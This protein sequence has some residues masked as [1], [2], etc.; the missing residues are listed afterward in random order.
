MVSDEKIGYLKINPLFPHR[1]KFSEIDIFDDKIR[2]AA[3]LHLKGDI[4]QCAPIQIVSNMLNNLLI[5]LSDG[6]NGSQEEFQKN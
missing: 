2:C 3:K 5:I 1:K 6:S 4:S